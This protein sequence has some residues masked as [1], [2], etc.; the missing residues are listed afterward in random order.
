[1]LQDTYVSRIIELEN[2]SSNSAVQAIARKLRLPDNLSQAISSEI[3]ENECEDIPV[4]KLIKLINHAN[5]TTTT[6]TTSSNAQT[7]IT[8]SK[9][10]RSAFQI[11]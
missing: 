11:V 2:E 10:F 9:A 7:T 8:F 5:D 4:G 3:I 1:M 6:T